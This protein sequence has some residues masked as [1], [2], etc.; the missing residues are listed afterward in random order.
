MSAELN[1]ERQDISERR[2]KKLVWRILVAA[3]SFAMISAAGCAGGAATGRPDSGAASAARPDADAST[4]VP[5]AQAGDE[6]TLGWLNLPWV[7]WLK[8]PVA[9]VVIGVVMAYLLILAANLLV[10]VIR[11]ALP[12]TQ[13]STTPT[14]PS[15]GRWGMLTARREGEQRVVGSVPQTREIVPSDRGMH[16]DE[17]WMPTTWRKSIGEFQDA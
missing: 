3:L 17:K 7:W 16:E 2:G 6:A 11:R 9:V 12:V 8:W 14:N 15:G 4:V 1:G 5:Q 10:F 13:Y